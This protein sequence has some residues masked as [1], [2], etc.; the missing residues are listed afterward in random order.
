MVEFN[1]IVLFVHGFATG[2][3]D[4]EQLAAAFQQGG[5]PTK[6]I[7][8]HG[9][10]EDDFSELKDQDFKKWLNQLRKEIRRLRRKGYTKIVVAGFSIGGLLGLHLA[11]IKDEIDGVLGI[12]TFLGPRFKKIAKLALFF[13]RTSKHGLRRFKLQTTVPAKGME[14]PHVGHNAPLPYGPMSSIIECAEMFLKRHPSLHCPVVLVHSTDDMVSGYKQ[15]SEFV[16]GTDS[17]DVLLVTFHALNHFIQYDMDPGLLCSLSML[18]FFKDNIDIDALREEKSL[19]RDHVIVHESATSDVS[20]REEDSRHWSGIIFQTIAGFFVVFGT[21]LMFTAENVINPETR[22]IRAVPYY[23]LLYSF[24]ISI[25]IHLSVLYFYYLNRN[26]AYI[27]NFIEP[28]MSGT[29]FVNYRT[30]TYLSGTSSDKMTKSVSIIISTLPLIGSFILIAGLPILFSD[31]FT[32]EPDNVLIIIGWI[33]GFTF[34]ITGLRASITVLNH[35]LLHMYTIPAQRISSPLQGE[36]ITRLHNSVVPGCYR[37]FSR[38]PDIE[39]REPS[40]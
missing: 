4:L 13:N 34:C 6:S 20:R 37:N 21:L 38:E 15:V 16:K 36:F 23:L 8:L 31:R 40:V 18:R 7:T 19:F 30:N 39:I 29:E 10:E 14:P 11:E 27:R 32:A 17:D 28:Y 24:V 22:D 35:S 9:H 12:S 2:P 1:P 33:L 25:Y 5:I 3:E 26:D